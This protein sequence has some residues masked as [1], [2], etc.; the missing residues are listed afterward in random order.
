M[1]A[2]PKFF[3][4]SAPVAYGGKDAKSPLAFR[5][6][7]KD[8]VVRGRGREITAAG[9]EFCHRASAEAFI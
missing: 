7:D 3:G 2:S 9:S 8:R 1:N 5:W 4:A 6:Y